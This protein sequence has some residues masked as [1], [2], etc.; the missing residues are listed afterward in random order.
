MGWICF[1]LLSALQLAVLL[2][3]LETVRRLTDFAGP[4]IWIA[5]LALA[6]WML[7]PCRLDDR[8][9]RRHD[10]GDPLRRPPD[11]GHRIGRLHRRRLHGGT[12]PQLRGLHAECAQRE[13]R[14]PGNALGLLINAS[15][16]GVV[17]VVIAL[18]AHEVYGD[19]TKDL[20]DLVRDIDSVTIL[21]VTII[22][23]AI[24]TA[25]VNIICNFVAPVYDLIN[26]RPGFFTFK[27]AGTLVAVLAVAVTPWN[28][29][30][31][32]VIVNQLIGS[33]GAFMGPLF[34]IITVDYYHPARQEAPCGVTL[35]RR[36]GRAVLLPPGV[37]P[38]GDRPHS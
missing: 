38:A 12:V 28:L 8:P 9:V 31:S 24:A 14:A 3:G 13:V 33:I 34:G 5:V 7:V 4:T 10:P 37:Q 25:G 23:V 27:R 15:L 11:A 1:L 21:L 18:S 36:S 26:I 6:V 19:E 35:L 22:A 30:S 17:A 29:F 2:S 20:V 32:P 16:F